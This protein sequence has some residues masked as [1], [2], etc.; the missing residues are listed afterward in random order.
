MRISCESP[1][2]GDIFDNKL[3]RRGR[4]GVNDLLSVLSANL[5]R[6]PN[7][8]G[9]LTDLDDFSP[10]NFG[11]RGRNFFFDQI[12]QQNKSIRISPSNLC[13]CHAPSPFLLKTTENRRLFRN[14]ADDETNRPRIPLLGGA[15]GRAVKFSHLTPAP[16]RRRGENKRPSPSGRGWGVGQT[17]FK[18]A[19]PHTHPLPLPRGE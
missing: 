5:I 10:D 2:K 16:L 6:V 13:P 15:R 3:L 17:S 14:Y 1:H 8:F 7:F 19:M 12:T 9:I 11:L 4:Q 18:A